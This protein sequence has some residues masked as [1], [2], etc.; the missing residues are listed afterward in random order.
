MCEYDAS[1]LARKLA[2]KWHLS[3]A[4]RRSL[5]IAGLPAST[6]VEAVRDILRTNPWYPPTWRRDEP[7]YDGVVIS[8]SEHGFA[9]H[10]RHEIGM[11][12]FSDATITEVATLEEAVRAFLMATFKPNDIDGILIDWS[13]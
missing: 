12:R 3:V 6:L 9:I 10:E 7:A 5:P 4:E 1:T 13:R 11:G 8:Q 2:E